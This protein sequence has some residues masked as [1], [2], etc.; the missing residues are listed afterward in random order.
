MTE[1][2]T[3]DQG[4]VGQGTSLGIVNEGRQKGWGCQD[5]CDYEAQVIHG[6]VDLLAQ[7]QVLLGCKADVLVYCALL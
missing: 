6:V 1:G 2:C 3:H 5:C 7:C 4:L